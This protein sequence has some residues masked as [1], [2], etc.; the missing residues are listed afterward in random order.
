MLALQFLTV[1][2]K[3]RDVRVMLQQS[4]FFKDVM[5]CR[6]ANSCQIWRYYFLYHENQVV[7]NLNMKTPRSTNVVQNFF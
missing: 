7:S 6:L 1:I 3:L 5:L 2:V 4:S